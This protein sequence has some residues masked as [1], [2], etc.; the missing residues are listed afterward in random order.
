MVSEELAGRG[1]V[2]GICLRNI[3]RVI[4]VSLNKNKVSAE[5]AW[6]DEHW[7]YFDRIRQE[8]VW[9]I[10][11]KDFAVLLRRFLEKYRF[12]RAPRPT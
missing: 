3:L 4:Q 11:F 10:D 7:A 9:V 12:C 6:N 5:E 8:D 1:F 2:V